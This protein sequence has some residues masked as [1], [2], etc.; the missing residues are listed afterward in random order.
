MSE[1]VIK[2][3][4][5]NECSVYNSCDSDSSDCIWS[6][7]N[8]CNHPDHPCNINVKDSRKG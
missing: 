1:K 3:L 5:E 8:G 7:K 2:F 6:S 4:E